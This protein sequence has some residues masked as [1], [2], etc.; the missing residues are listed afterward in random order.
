[1]T[2]Q[3]AKEILTLYRP[4]RDL[5]NRD[6]RQREALALVK[7]DPALEQWFE[8]HCAF[9]QAVSS[10]LKEIKP[11]AGLKEAILAQRQKIVPLPVWWRRPS[12]LAAAAILLF[13]LG[14]AAL[15]FRG[16]PANR[17]ADYRSRMIST[18]LR[19]Y[20]MD[21]ETN[22]M[23]QVRYYMASRGAP[24]DYEITAG[25]ERLSVAGGGF[26]RWRDHPVS[27]VCF[28]RPDQKMVYLFVL[29]KSAVGDPPALPPS[30]RPAEELETAV[31]SKGDK[32]Y[33]LAAPPDPDFAGKY[34]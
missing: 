11:P 24:S 3:E 18:V 7:S 13:L 19:E 22:D 32:T 15:L 23:A 8:N 20:R 33:L 25:L 30:I 5:G 2:H 6:V 4:G 14:V 29:A 10:K 21:V 27:M 26:L 12:L 9:Q 17:F 1:M 16:T 31:W 34:L 28:R